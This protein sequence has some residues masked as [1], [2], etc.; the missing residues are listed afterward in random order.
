LRTVLALVLATVLTVAGCTPESPA[1]SPAGHARSAAPSH[2]PRFASYVA[3]GDSF[4]AGP[5]VPRTELAAGCLRSDGNYPSLVARRLHVKHF[6]DVS[7]SGAQTR[8]LTHRQ[9]TF[10]DATVPPQLD[11]VRAGT[12]L[13]T[14][15]IGG[16]DFDLFEGL[17]QRCASLRQFAPG[18]APCTV[19]LRRDGFDPR[20]VT[21]RIGEHVA[22]AVRRIRARA[23]GAEVLVVGYLRLA[24]TR[25]GCPALPFAAGDYAEGVRVS[26]ALDRALAGAA[27]RTGA[28]F[29]DMYAASRGHD[30]CSAHPW[31]NGSRTDRAAALAFHPLA[32]GMDAVADRVVAR[33]SAPA[34]AGSASGGPNRGRSQ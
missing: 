4:T 18:G 19:Q 21:R 7:C 20:R 5:Y 26:R 30:V 14:L 32:A 13:V 17:L 25:G 29:I 33:L 28:G 15:G 11:A 22:T 9:H 1:K 27:H 2:A 10:R 16:N 12:D 23:P 31:V 34:G 6:T 8:D 3:L 24:P